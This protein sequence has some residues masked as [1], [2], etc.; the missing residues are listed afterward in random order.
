V[1]FG[2]F[3]PFLVTWLINLTGDPMIPAWYLM[4][5]T[6]LALAALK[7][8]PESAALQSRAACA[9]PRPPL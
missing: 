1:L 4:G 9:V 7:Q 2:G 6:A 3:S 5:A 8:F